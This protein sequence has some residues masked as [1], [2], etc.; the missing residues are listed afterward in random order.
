MAGPAVKSPGPGRGGRK[1]E[2]RGRNWAQKP[3]EGM[4]VFWINC[5]QWTLCMYVGVGALGGGG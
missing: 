2:A 1:P 5:I 3:T 4:G